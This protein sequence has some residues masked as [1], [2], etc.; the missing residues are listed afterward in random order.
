MHIF[1]VHSDRRLVGTP[2]WRVGGDESREA[3]VTPAART[4]FSF[5]QFVVA[6]ARARYRCFMFTR[7]V[8]LFGINALLI[9]VSIP[10][11]PSTGLIEIQVDLAVST[12]R[13]PG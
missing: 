1:S 3:L 13:R 9:Q 5:S 4:G 12:T 6:V 2:I 11:I 7:A 10:Q 8:P